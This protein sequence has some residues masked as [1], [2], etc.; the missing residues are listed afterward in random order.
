[1]KI[2]EWLKNLSENYYV[3]VDENSEIVILP[4][5]EKE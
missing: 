3:D 5:E 1:M 2:S 4:I